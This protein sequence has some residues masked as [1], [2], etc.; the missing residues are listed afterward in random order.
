MDDLLTRQNIAVETDLDRVVLTIE[1]LSFPMPYAAS[2][3]IAAGIKQA[4]KEAMRV[5]KEPLADW[6]KWLK[7]DGEITVNEIH[8]TRRM[9]ITK[10]FDWKVIFEG[11]MVHLHL[12]DNKVGF[13]FE[14]GFKISQWL[15]LAGK[16]AKHWAGDSGSHMHLTG[17]LTDAEHNYK[18]GL[19]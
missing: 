7:L 3:R 18:L 13:H 4:C 15:R 11:E 16:Q 10:K 17:H 19:E 5:S 14:T 1:R 8:T 2:F 12:G 9:T 6:Q